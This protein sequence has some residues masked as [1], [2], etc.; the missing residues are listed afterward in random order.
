MF[1][2]DGRP[3]SPILNLG[4]PD[5]RGEDILRAIR[6]ADLPIRVTITTG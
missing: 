5:A 4:L 3:I 6:E 2:R 1:A